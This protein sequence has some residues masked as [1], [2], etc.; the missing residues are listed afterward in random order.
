MPC[1]AV[2]E[3]T[4][5]LDT[6]FNVGLTG[7]FQHGVSRKL[8][9]TGSI[10]TYFEPTDTR[11]DKIVVPVGATGVVLNVTTFTSGTR[12]PLWAAQG[13]CL[14]LRCAMY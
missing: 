13:G 5:V 9:V 4:R 14:G 7:A 1:G 10:A 6:R 8:T 2:V 3:P 11:E 12:P